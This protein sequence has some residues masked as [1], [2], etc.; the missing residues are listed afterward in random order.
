MKCFD[1]GGFSPKSIARLGPSNGALQP[2]SQS[3]FCLDREGGLHSHALLQHPNHR[4]K[5]DDAWRSSCSE[6]WD[7]GYNPA[8]FQWTNLVLCGS[9]N[10]IQLFANKKDSFTVKLKAKVLGA[11]SSFK[12]HH[13]QTNCFPTTAWTLSLQGKSFVNKLPSVSIRPNG[14]QKISTNFLRWIKQLAR[15]SSLLVLEGFERQSRK[16][17]KHP[18]NRLT[19]ET[20]H[21]SQP[22]IGMMLDAPIFKQNTQKLL[23]LK[24]QIQLWYWRQFHTRQSSRKECWHTCTN[25]QRPPSCESPFGICCSCY[26]SIVFLLS[27][28]SSFLNNFCHTKQ[29]LWGINRYRMVSVTSP[30]RDETSVPATCCRFLWSTWYLYEW[31]LFITCD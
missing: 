4:N 22:D 1:V 12:N 14:S 16:Q 27:L 19:A 2:R 28:G 6:K 20:T 23:L 26:L 31:R 30:G 10:F 25:N 7:G 9:G 24:G 29:G 8:I 11:V 17:K 15:L 21:R 18:T 13:H 5:G 3:T